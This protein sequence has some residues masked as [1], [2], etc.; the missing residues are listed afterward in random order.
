M[1]NEGKIDLIQFDGGVL[2]ADMLQDSQAEDAGELTQHAVE[3]GSDIADHFIFRPRTMTLTLVQ[4]QTPIESDPAN[5][6]RP[7]VANLE[8]ASRTPGSQTATVDIPQPVFRPT[9]LLALTG[10]VQNAIFGGPPK[11]LTITGLKADTQVDLKPFSVTVLTADAEVDRV[12]DFYSKLLALFEGVVPL[13]VTVKS[14]TYPDMIITSVRRQDPQ[15]QAGCARF[16][17]DL[18]RIATTQTQTVELPPVPAA[19]KKQSNGGKPANPAATERSKTAAA[20]VF[21]MATGAAP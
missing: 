4:T 17:V 19:T 13:Q 9:S 18:T 6:F 21:D 2:V 5:G 1:A 11:T 16:T 10:A 14:R 20:A 12:N 15:G 3:D 7:Q 8:I